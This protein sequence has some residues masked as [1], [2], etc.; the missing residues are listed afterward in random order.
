MVSS[1]LLHKLLIQGSLHLE[2]SITEYYLQEKKKASLQCFQ[3]KTVG[4]EWLCNTSPSA[5]FAIKIL[6]NPVA[7]VLITVRNG[8]IF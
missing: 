6:L 4:N 1:M 8:S 5:L 2:Y 3:M 7:N